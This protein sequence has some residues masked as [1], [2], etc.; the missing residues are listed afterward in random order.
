MSVL[1]KISI[2]A[3]LISLSA[4]PSFLDAADVAVKK[5]D[6]KTVLAGKKCE[7]VTDQLIDCYEL[8]NIG[9]EIGMEVAMA[10]SG[11]PE[12]SE[13]PDVPPVPGKNIGERRASQEQKI[14]LFRMWK[15]I[16]DV[17]LTDEQVDKFFPLMRDMQKNERELAVQRNS[18]LK[19]LRLELDKEKPDEATL[20]TLITKIE[21][22]GH[23]IW[24]T[25]QEAVDKIKI[26]LTVEQQA[27][28]LLSLNSMDR[29]IWETVA[30]LR[31]P[32]SLPD[33][34]LD[35]EKFRTNMEDVRKRLDQIKT[36]LKAKGL[37]IDDD[38]DKL[39]PAD[40]QKV[41]AKP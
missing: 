33:F 35:Q 30:R 5:A 15:I 34:K 37:P 27:R 16:N 10:F 23:Q 4:L 39:T 1:K 8:E 38:L 19:D 17:N 12:N 25:K 11:G 29:D 28:F 24:K 13:V 14:G 40:S 31:G 26:F 20:R 6:Q 41:K 22:N 2:I 32:H 21:A 18:F 36:E 3:V 9:D 7:P